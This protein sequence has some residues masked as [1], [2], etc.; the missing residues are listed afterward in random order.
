MKKSNREV[1]Y[2]NYID[3]TDKDYSL[4]YT[5]IHNVWLKKNF[6]VVTDNNTHSTEFVNTSFT[7]QIQLRDKS[8]KEIKSKAN[9][10]VDSIVSDYIIGLRRQKIEKIKS[11]WTSK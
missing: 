3:A 1:K 5:N 8:I 11:K 2:F 7:V 4:T 9:G 10:N 6:K